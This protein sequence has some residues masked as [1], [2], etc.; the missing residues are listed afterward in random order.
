MDINQFI[1]K[2]GLEGERRERRQFWKGFTMRSSF[3]MEMVFI[4]MGYKVME[5]WTDGYR[6]VAVNE[7]ECSIVT[8][9]EGDLH[10]EL[11]DDADA[12]EWGFNSAATFYNAHGVH[13]S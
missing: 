13:A 2:Y 3:E 10:L 8:Y 1:K 9:V 11:F 12:Y 4:S 6:I 7:D 5:D